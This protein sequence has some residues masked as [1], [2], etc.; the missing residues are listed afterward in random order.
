MKGKIMKLA[1]SITY[2]D[3]F[4]NKF[5]EDT[6]KRCILW[7]QKKCGLG[8]QFFES[9]STIQKMLNLV[10]QELNLQTKR[11]IPYMII[12]CLEYVTERTRICVREKSE[13]DN[14]NIILGVDGQLDN[15][16]NIT[17]I[18]DCFQAAGRAIM[19]KTTNLKNIDVTIYF[20]NYI[21]EL[22]IIDIILDIAFFN[23]YSF[24]RELS[25]DEKREFSKHKFEYFLS[26]NMQTVFEETRDNDLGYYSFAFSCHKTDILDV[27]NYE[28]EI[29]IVKYIKIWESFIDK[30]YKGKK[31]KEVSVEEQIKRRK[32]KHMPDDYYHEFDDAAP[33]VYYILRTEEKNIP[34][35]YVKQV[36]SLFGKS[37][38]TVGYLTY[39]KSDEFGKYTEL[40]KYAGVSAFKIVVQ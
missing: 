11:N 16:A 7:D 20:D 6:I 40:Y 12:D 28:Y 35:K 25:I 37:E 5:S 34:E 18:I 13:F 23:S 9:I 31:H 1:S 33:G 30:Y 4:L 3:N 36:L 38:M 26:E 19:K 14:E 39:I 29:D 21:R 24:L 15:F 10:I 22:T 27:S 8:Q 2:Q 32:N 17:H